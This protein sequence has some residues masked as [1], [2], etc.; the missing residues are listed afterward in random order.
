M[1]VV[2]WSRTSAGCRSD[3]KLQREIKTR[4]ETR[5]TRSPSINLL[6]HEQQKL[7]V[8]SWL[9]VLNLTSEQRQSLEVL[10][11]VGHIILESR[12]N[13]IRSRNV[14]PLPY[15]LYQTTFS[16]TALTSWTFPLLPF[17]QR[18]YFICSAPRPTA[19][20]WYTSHFRSLIMPREPQGNNY[21][22]NNILASFVLI[23]FIKER[24]NTI[25]G[26]SEERLREEV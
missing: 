24:R 26:D 16:S 20:N 5:T 4:F 25:M 19:Q 13:P 6:L 21:S 14:L 11:P 23:V 15:Y 2:R 10:L 17:K 12:A 8:E 9:V 22:P 3:D 18:F 1:S 7:L